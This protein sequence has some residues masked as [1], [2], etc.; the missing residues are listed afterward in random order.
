[1]LK[2]VA[3]FSDLLP[4]LVKLF[5]FST[6]F[7]ATNL[8]A[9]QEQSRPSLPEIR[10]QHRPYK[11]IVVL[12]LEGGADSFSM[13]IPLSGCD[14]D[15]Y[16][17][18]AA[19]RGNIAL[20]QSQILP[21]IVVDL[22]Y[23][24]NTQ[25]PCTT[26]GTHPV[27][28][29]VQTL[30]DAGEASWF[31]NI[32]AL[33]EPTNLVEYNT[34]K[35]EGRVLR[36]PP[37][38]FGH[39]TQQRQ[40]QSVHSDNTGAKGVLG[41]MM[42]ALTA[43]SVPYRTGA[44]SM[45]GIRK[46]LEG[47]VPSTVMGLSGVNRFSQYG[48]LSPVLRNITGRQSA[49]IFADTYAGILQKTLEETERLGAQLAGVTLV[50]TYNGGTGIENVARTIVLR[51]DSDSET[52]SE[53]DVFMVGK[54]T[55]DSHQNPYSSTASLLELFNRDLEAL[56]TDMTAIGMWNS[57]TVVTISD[58]ART[59]TSNG[60]GTDHAWGGNNFILGGSVQGQ[61]IHGQFPDDLNPETSELEVGRGR[62][63]LIPTTPWEGMW[64][65]V[66]QWFGI[67]EDQMLTVLPNAA[68]F[69]AGSTLLTEEQLFK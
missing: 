60:L 24:G 9:L 23:E 37:S 13:L 6:E 55:F 20:A 41:R 3:D 65:G 18:Y 8:N 21:M 42:E 27:L 45:Y 32:G 61:R 51:G 2:R 64:Y 39:D 56:H 12:F 43:Q 48:S 25:Q 62:G 46:L 19:V 16:A 1:M 30:W 44:Y 58:F 40:C 34:K 10:T 14:R 63:V 69:K 50:G 68:N 7:H 49:S 66:A 22:D 28:S 29:I 38:L 17:E 57:V 67:E 53:R 52:N 54:R 5:A 47:D 35:K 59:L 4:E 31:A 36:L 33:V 15:L 11:A 26:F